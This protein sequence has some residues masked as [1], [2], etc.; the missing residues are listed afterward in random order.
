[1]ND[2]FLRAYIRHVLEEVQ[3]NARVPDQLRSP[4]GAKN[5]DEKDTH[6][7]SD[8]DPRKSGNHKEDEVDEVNVVGNIVGM[9][10]PL[11]MSP[12]DP[13][14]TGTP[15]KKKKLKHGWK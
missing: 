15:R 13:S 5:P 2:A 7:S 10:L 8:Y 14:I 4:K 6:T 1:M 11:G 3:D 9:T 12:G